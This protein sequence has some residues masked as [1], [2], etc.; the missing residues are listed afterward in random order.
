MFCQLLLRITVLYRLN[1]RTMITEIIM[2][3]NA[4]YCCLSLRRNSIQVPHHKWLGTMAWKRCHNKLFVQLV[5]V[6]DYYVLLWVAICFT[7][8]YFKLALIT[9]CRLICLHNICTV[10]CCLQIY[11]FLCSE[12]SSTIKIDV[13]SRALVI[14]KGIVFN[15]G[16]RLITATLLSTQS[17][18]LIA[19]CAL[20]GNKTLK[21]ESCFA[22]KIVSNFRIF[23]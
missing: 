5:E 15:F 3:C 14:C 21:C 1:C 19:L 22:K 8:T 2:L 9:N 17:F 6:H 11:L 20:T 23:H 18:R 13:M 12:T 16:R 10:C 7:S 4:V